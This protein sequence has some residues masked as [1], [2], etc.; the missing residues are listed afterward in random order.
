MKTAVFTVM[1]RIASA[2]IGVY[3]QKQQVSVTHIEKTA[4]E[5]VSC[6]GNVTQQDGSPV[7][8]AKIILADM[9]GVT[10]AGHL[11]SQTIVTQAEMAIQEILDITLKRTH[12]SE[13]GLSILKQPF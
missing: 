8:T 7:V 9:K 6:L 4:T 13:T 5:V 12:D 1:G 2:T 11:F 3:D 10:T